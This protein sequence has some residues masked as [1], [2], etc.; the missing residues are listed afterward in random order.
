M[1]SLTAQVVYLLVH[2][3]VLHSVVPDLRDDAHRRNPW[4]RLQRKSVVNDEARDAVVD[5]ALWISPSSDLSL[6]HHTVSFA[7]LWR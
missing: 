1:F 3:P 2:I 7:M 4:L 5:K 6:G